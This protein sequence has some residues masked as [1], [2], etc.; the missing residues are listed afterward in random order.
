MRRSKSLAAIALF[1][2]LILTAAACSNETT[3]TTPGATGGGDP[4]KTDEFG[5]ATYDAGAP[6]RI[7]TLLA[8]SGDVATLGVDS[9]HGVQLGVDYLDGQFDA[10]PGQLVGHDVSL[11]SEDD[12]CSKDGGQSGATKLAADPTILSV[13]GTSCSSSALGVADKILGDKGILLIS[14][15]N[16]AAGLTSLVGH[17]PFYLRTAQNDAIQAKV[18]ADFVGTELSFTKAATIHDESPYAA[19]LTDG[20]KTFFE[21]SRI[22]G[23]VTAAEQITSTDTDFK[24]LLT[25]IAQTGPQLIYLPDFNPA[26]AL[27][28]KQA[29]DIP[30][31]ANVALMGSDGCNASTFFDQAGSAGDGFYLSSPIPSPGASSGGLLA[32]YKKAY[33]DQYGAETASFNANAFDAFNILV[34]AIKK[35]AIKGS[36]GSVKIPRSALH[37]AI[38]Q[39]KDYQ[40]ITGPLT[41]LDTGDCQSQLA[42]NIGVYKSPDSPV[43]PATPDAKP[44]FNETFSLQEALGG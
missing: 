32:T 12:L 36:D 2:A 9:F 40:G 27:I 3:T 23:T 30:D 28:A 18:V 16:T 20:F 42:V 4:C 43:N 29:K 37:D 31:L 17:N 19:G 13:I 35:V 6:I 5:C 41:C 33:K 24:P 22:G 44:I 15:S 34:E 26:C 39:T 38:F 1:G 10:K 21:G 7:G 8:I 14:P 25:S 11:Q